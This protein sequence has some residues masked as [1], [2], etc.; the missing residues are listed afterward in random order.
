MAYLEKL[1]F[2]PLTAETWECLEQ[3]FGPS[4]TC[5][6]CWCTWWRLSSKDFEKMTR[7]EK[8]NYIRTIVQ[9]GKTPGLLAFVDGIPAGWVSVAPRQEF[10]RMSRSKTLAPTDDQ[11]VWSI[12][13]F[14]IDRHYRRSGLTL[15]LIQE[16]VKFAFSRGAKI[17]EAYPIDPQEKT[18][19]GSLYY[20]VA[21]TFAMVG[22]V[23]VA[24]RSPVHPIMRLTA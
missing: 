4:R 1:T 9:S 20:G 23:E 10:S 16:A 21:S 7:E 17:I 12:N 19:S 22:F 15:E 8:K 2:S 18:E 24:R 14:F 11:P 13:C 3:L 5:T 6:G